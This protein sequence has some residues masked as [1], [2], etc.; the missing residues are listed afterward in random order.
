MGNDMCW[1]DQ[2]STTFYFQTSWNIP[3][4]L[5]PLKMLGVEWP[6]SLIYLLKYKT[7]V[8]SSTFSVFYK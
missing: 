8:D 3:Y 7:K 1:G 5:N 2:K 6:K 4:Q